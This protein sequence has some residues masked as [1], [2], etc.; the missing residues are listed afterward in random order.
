MIPA[1]RHWRSVTASILFLGAGLLSSLGSTAQAATNATSV[2]WSNLSPGDDWTASVLD[3]LFP[4]SSSADTVTGLVLATVCSYV[5]LLAATWLSYASM[6][7]LHRT[8]ESGK[9]LSASFSGWVPLRVVVACMMMLPVVNSFSVGQAFVVT[10]AKDA[11]G[12]ARNLSNVVIESIGPKGFPLAE[13]MIPGTRKVV[14]GVMEA[15]LCRAL[16]NVAS[17]NDNLVPLPS[18]P[19]N[20]TGAAV[21]R[22]SLASGDQGSA[23]VCGAI[24]IGIPEVLSTTTN[25]DGIDW[26]SLVNAHIAALNSLIAE[27]RPAMTTL[28]TTYWETRNSTVLTGMDA[29]LLSAQKNYTAA[30]TT[31]ATSAVATI[32]ATYVKDGDIEA[33]PGIAAMRALGWSSLAAYYLE[34]SRANSEVLAATSIIPAVS[35]PTY[36]GIGNALV[37]D[38]GGIADAIRQYQAKQ[39]ASLVYTDTSTAPDS[40]TGLF[41]DGQITSNPEGLLSKVT[42][43]LGL[44]PAVLN[45]LINHIASAS[46]GSDW[47][48]PFAA[49]I[50]LGHALIHVAL[51]I[52]AGVAI[53]SSKGLTIAATAGATLTGNFGA[54]AAGIGSLA[55][56]GAIK[57]LTTWVFLGAFLLLAPGITLAYGLPMMPFAYWNI[58][59]VGWLVLVVELV[60]AVPFWALAHMVFEG[61]GLHGKG[62]RGYEALFT[63]LFRPV[64]MIV[65]LVVSYTIFSASSWL[66]MKG[67]TV[68]SGF[69]LAR[70]YLVDNVIGVVVLLV[71]FA[72]MEMALAVTS[73]RLINTLPHHLATW[74]GMTSVGRVDSD[75]YAERSTGRGSHGTG[76]AIADVARKSFEGSNKPVDRK[77]EG[78]LD[79]TIQSMMRPIGRPIE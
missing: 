8:A 32:R 41:D 33:D 16:I 42:E 51:A 31:A 19:T 63:V 55:F 2:T 39:E 9:I 77:D 52:I 71:M 37:S 24:A 56:Q 35:A 13:P 27:V 74:V 45:G 57:V 79:S 11:V 73:F 43:G 20:A 62:R 58:G 72:S 67:F 47:V 1:P 7:Q 34:I 48:D 4:M 44:G 21:L 28:A 49:L 53:A 38:L 15:E 40:A 22:Y 5:A 18:M 50:S 64:M 68:A 61:D 69:V 29:V 3:T 78:G 54:T 59:V 76:T 23:P 30:L 65:G 70:G 10:V 60:I 46:S 26:S 12:M 36:Q 17:G 66:L 25:G 6:L 75:D 14:M